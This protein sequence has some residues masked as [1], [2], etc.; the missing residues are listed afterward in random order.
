[1]PKAVAFT[2]T[3]L[4]ELSTGKRPRGSAP[5]PGSFWKCLCSLPA[6]HITPLML[7]SVPLCRNVAHSP[8]RCLRRSA[9]PPDLRS[10]GGG[11]RALPAPLGVPGGPSV[12]CRPSVPVSS[13][14]FLFFCGRF[15]WIT[16]CL[17][18]YKENG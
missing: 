12:I 8:R 2:A 14:D 3:S 15:L 16:L 11:Q 7:E 10:D 6:A 13:G 18:E 5:C 17:L 4:L 1:M 9:L